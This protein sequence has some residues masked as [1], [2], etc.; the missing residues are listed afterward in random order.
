MLAALVRLVWLLA[1]AIGC[2]GDKPLPPTDQAALANT[3]EALAQMGE[4]Q[5]GTP[6]G[7][8][9]ADYIR[10][11]FVELGLTDVHYETFQFPRWELLHKSLSIT[12]DGVPS[13][14]AFDV[15][16]A[17][18]GGTAD[19]PIVDVST[20]TDADL[21]GVDLTGKIAMV[22]RD[23][24]FHRSSQLRNV[25]AK[26]AA[27]MLYLSVAPENLR[28]VGSVRLDWEPAATIPAITIG[29]DDATTIKNALAA[30]QTVRAQIDVQIAS[31]PGTGIDVVGTIEGER[32][33][34]IM[35]GAH[36]DTWFAGSSD[37]GSGVAELLAIAQRRKQQKKPHYTLVFVAYDGEEIGL[38]GGYDFYRKHRIV[39]NEP[40][41]VALNFECPSAVDPDIAA[42]VHSNQ[43]KL[44]EALQLA[45]LRQIYSVYAGLEIV[46][47]LFGGIIPTDIQGAYRGGTPTATTA[48]TNPYY[49]TI[50]DTPEAVDLQLLADSTDAFD[51]AIGYLG[52]LAPADFAVLDPH[53]WTADVT[54]N[55]ST[56]DVI[57]RD[58][59]GAPQPN[60]K[61]RA[62][63][64]RD[65][66]FL[67]GE[68]NGTSDAS[69]HVQLQLPASAL[70]D[71]AGNRFIH[72]TAGPV[73][74]LVEKII[75]LP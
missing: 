9:A 39:N 41:L 11:R 57:V 26:G 66:F 13:S 10:G 50:K 63:A 49:H 16:E 75:A 8:Q 61:V 7:A 28:Q 32:P 60:A 42:V 18:G 65:D 6:A 37:N 20:A 58:A 71:G 72:V 40:I 43:P 68:A 22:K 14:P 19:G 24:S 48:V 12:I 62:T 3:L 23:A 46:A 54:L 38:Y 36:Y 53:L 55:G 17:S 35:L 21:V 34:I 59:N 2:D 5:A 1:F 73:Y 70:T 4:K 27:A 51:A 67:S 69:G 56:V 33:E 64:L 15:F 29:A 31:T 25:A 30:G 52:K 74:P 45:H 47:Q 44:D